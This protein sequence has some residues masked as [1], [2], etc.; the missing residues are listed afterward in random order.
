MIPLKALVPRRSMPLM[1]LAL[2]LSNVLVF[3]YELSLGPHAIE[4]FFFQYGMIPARIQA[5]VTT[6]TVPLTDALASIFTSMFVHGGWL[7]I[8]GNMWFLWVFGIVIE[9]QLG[10]LRYL[11]FYLV[12][13]VGAALTQAIVGWGARVPTIGA[14]G[15][16]SGIMGAYF[17]LL[18]TSRV[19]TLMPLIIFWF[20][21]RLPAIVMIGYWFLVQLLSATVQPPGAGGV[22]FWAH[23]GGFVL[24]ALLAFPRR[25]SGHWGWFYEP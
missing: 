11:A 16:I 4:R 15:A 7:H 5:A 2:I 19:L 9:D 1:T 8:I 3:F 17:V 25:R 21:M 6:G 18:P 24:G 20:T 14:S 10:R 13:G 22:A 23:V 12:C